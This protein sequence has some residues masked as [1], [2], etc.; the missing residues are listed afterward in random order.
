MK[1]QDRSDGV[2]FRD[3]YGS[4][5]DLAVVKRHPRGL[6]LEK[7][8]NVADPMLPRSRHLM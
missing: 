5:G 2:T 6:R 4:F 3:A 8:S 7:I 1:I